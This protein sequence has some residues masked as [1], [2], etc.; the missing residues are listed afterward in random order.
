MSFVQ[1]GLRPYPGFSMKRFRLI[2]FA[3][4]FGTALVPPVPPPS[5]G[6]GR[7]WNVY[8]TRP[9]AAA[10]K[11]AVATPEE[12]LCRLVGGSKASFHGAFYSL[13]LPAV[14]GKI[15][16]AYRRGVDVRLVIERSN[17]LRPEVG[18]LVNAGIPVVADGN[19]ALM[20]NKFAVIDGTTVWTG[21]FNLTGNCAYR[22]NNNAIEIQSEELARIF[23]AEFEEMHEKRVFGNRR[24][25]GIFP[26]LSR[27]YYVKIEDT[28]INAYFSP[29]DNIERILL[30]RIRKAHTSVHFMAFSFTSDALGE[31]LI[32]IFKEGRAVSGIMEREGSDS[33]DSEYVKM[34]LEGIPVR[35]DKNRHIMH[36]KVMIIDGD[37]VVT[38]SY[39]FTKSANVRNDE[40]VLIIENREIAGEYMEE[41]RRLYD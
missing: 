36:H 28:P 14:T 7:W 13:T 40:N 15:S 22:N 19:R 20:H 41:F 5:S 18:K 34:K 31:E 2:I 27:K 17:A 12:A 33:R 39:N 21:S 24:E 32:R 3:I 1:A 30:K 4:A 35:L 26:L 6:S 11:G 23:G 37:T 29:E 8:F 16:E 9:G 10:R 25:P 38:G